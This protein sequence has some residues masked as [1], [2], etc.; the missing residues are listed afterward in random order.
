MRHFSWRNFWQ[1]W[2]LPDFCCHC[3]RLGPLL[4][5]GCYQLVDFFWQGDRRQ[6]YA[7]NFREI[8]FDEVRVLAKFKAPLS[9]L[10]KALKYQHHRRGAQFLGQM[11]FWH[12]NVHWENYALIT[13]VPLHRQKLRHRGY[14]QSQLIAEELGRW[15]GLPVQELMERQR[16]TQAQASIK[17]K[18][19]RL[20]R[21]DQVFALKNLSTT[22]LASQKIILIDD[23]ITTGATVNAVCRELKRTPIA[24]ITVLALAHH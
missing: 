4:C 18:Q 24:W 1:A 5:E 12:L 2:L 17:D 15:T 19:E 8:Y 7:K 6:D 10:I 3:Q 14:N 20:A 11:L 16:H 9:Q 21:L 13:Y 23:V 22:H